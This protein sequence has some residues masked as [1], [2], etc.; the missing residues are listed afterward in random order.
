MALLSGDNHAD[1]TDMFR[2]FSS[3]QFSIAFKPVPK[4]NSRRLKEILT[5]LSHVLSSCA[6]AHGDMLR[7]RDEEGYMAL[8][9]ADCGRVTRVLDKPVIKG[10]RFRVEP[11]HGAP[12]TSARRVVEEA[13]RYPRSAWNAGHQD[14]LKLS[15]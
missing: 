12:Q 3:L 10:P 15:S 6:F 14:K 2:T 7:T 4:V 1:A 11:V 13:Q 5:S 9:C 8:E